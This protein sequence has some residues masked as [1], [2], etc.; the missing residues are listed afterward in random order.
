LVTEGHAVLTSGGDGNWRALFQG[1]DPLDGIWGSSTNDIHVVGFGTHLHGGTG[2]LA[3]APIANAP[4]AFLEKVWG[5]AA[6]DV[7]IVGDRGTI[8]HLK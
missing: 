8:L 4:T 2:G 1:S 5:S 6:N 3:D 7:Y